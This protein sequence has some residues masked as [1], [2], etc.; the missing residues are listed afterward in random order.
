V[1]INQK[2]VAKNIA[3][4]FCYYHQKIGQNNCHGHCRAVKNIQI[5]KI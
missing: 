4:A 3:T 1:S 5:K 2:A